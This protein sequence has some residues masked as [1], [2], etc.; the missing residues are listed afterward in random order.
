MSIA[1]KTL[2][3]KKYMYK[4]MNNKTQ[5]GVIFILL[6]IFIM[7]IKFTHSDRQLEKLIADK[8][9]SNHLKKVYLEI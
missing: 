8:V 3:V 1:N 4:I 7:E 9:I 5:K 2:T 6:L